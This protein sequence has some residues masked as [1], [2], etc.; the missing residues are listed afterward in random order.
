MKRAWMPVRIDIADDPRVRR[1]AR[2]LDL[3][4][5]A[6]VGMCVALWAW[7]QQHTVD[8]SLPFTTD[9]D[10]DDLVGRDGFADALRLIGWLETHPECADGIVFPRW[11]EY[12]SN[13]AKE[14]LQAA[15]RVAR[16]RVRKCYGES[17]TK[18]LH[19]RDLHNSKSKRREEDGA[20][21][22]SG[23]ARAS[24]RPSR[25]AVSWSIE[26][27][28]AGITDQDRANWAA[29]Y[30]AV[31]IE[32]A[33][34]EAHAWLVAN[35]TRTKRNYRRFLTN[36]FSRQQER[37]GDAASAGRAVPRGTRSDAADANQ[38]PAWRRDQRQRAESVTK[39]AGLAD[40][41]KS[42]RTAFRR[43]FFEIWPAER[44]ADAGGNAR[45]TLIGENGLIWRQFQRL[46]PEAAMR[47]LRHLAGKH[48]KPPTLT[49]IRDAVAAQEQNTIRRTAK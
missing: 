15:E 38:E 14:R 34:A 18:S 22:P 47:V 36:F 40:G 2:S 13:G 28:F 33:T 1:A 26:S 27:G 23:E 31:N 49:E 7:A 9:Q 16:Q 30:P 25:G 29:A 24:H 12:N 39:A 48:A 20:S 3:S 46:D 6:F 37:G 41:P 35:P 32:R 42:A 43:A 45:E 11:D 19:D 21:A 17:V 5:Y 10:I 44:F 8:G 4:R